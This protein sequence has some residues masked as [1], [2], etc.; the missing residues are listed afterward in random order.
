MERSENVKTLMNLL[1]SP[2]ERKKY[3]PDPQPYTKVLHVPKPHEA[4]DEKLVA[5]TLAAAYCGPDFFTQQEI[6]QLLND[7][8]T[9]QSFAKLVHDLMPDWWLDELAQEGEKLLNAIFEKEQEVKITL[10]LKARPS[11]LKDFAQELGPDVLEVIA[12]NH[13][14]EN[15]QI[16]GESVWTR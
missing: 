10:T 11:T 5:D 8:E 16:D 7:T 9:L 6:Q 15:V 1:T 2:I 13:Q 12:Q 4:P 3:R 14:I